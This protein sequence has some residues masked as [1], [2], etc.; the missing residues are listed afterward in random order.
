[1]KEEEKKA[2]NN[3]KEFIKK[4]WIQLSNFCYGINKKTLG[5]MTDKE[6]YSIEIALNLIEKQQAEIENTKKEYYSLINK[7]ENKIDNFDY[8]FVKAKRKNDN[9]R[10]DYYW[11]LI[12]NF[13]KLLEKGE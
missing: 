9:D 3:L 5:T 2:I 4:Q 8:E 10:A 7:I 6:I 12:I 13:K 11:D 1:M